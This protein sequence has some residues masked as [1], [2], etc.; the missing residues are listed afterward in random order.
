MSTVTS[1]T[2]LGRGLAVRLPNSSGVRVPSVTPAAMAPFS[3]QRRSRAL[4]IC[5]ANN[6]KAKGEHNPKTDVHPFKISPVVLVDLVEQPGERWQLKE[7]H[8][9]VTLWFEVPGHSREDLAVEIDE[10]VLVIKKRTNAGGGA[11][12][13]TGAKGAVPNSDGIYARLFLPA[14]YSKESVKAELKSGELMVSIGKIKEQARRKISV[15]I[16]AK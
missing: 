5:C 7:E 13:E 9:G 12:T 2:F 8:D 14:G 16:D 6:P 10:D 4:S 3:S 15:N 11:R 1:C